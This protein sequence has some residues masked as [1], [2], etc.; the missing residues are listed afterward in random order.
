M[1][2]R[3]SGYSVPAAQSAKMHPAT[4]VLCNAFVFDAKR[5]EGVIDL[6]SEWILAGKSSMLLCC[7]R[8]L[9]RTQAAILFI[10]IASRFEILFNA[11]TACLSQK[12]G[13]WLQ[14]KLF[15]YVCRS[16]ASTCPMVA[17]PF[18]RLS[19]YMM[20][21]PVWHWI[22]ASLCGLSVSSPAWVTGVFFHIFTVAR[23]LRAPFSDMPLEFFCGAT[24]ACL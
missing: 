18:P 13:G 16:G 14:S 7:R 15:R 5:G 3:L 17:M 2:R 22:A 23:P 6:Y 19:E 21:Y 11:H 1:H 9:S 8:V 20:S 24:E 12:M 10:F 4:Q